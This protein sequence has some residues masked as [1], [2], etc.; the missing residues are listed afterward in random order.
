[1]KNIAHLIL[2]TLL[3]AGLVTKGSAEEKTDS[4]YTGQPL[5]LTIIEKEVLDATYR[6]D[7]EG[8]TLLTPGLLIDAL[9][10]VPNGAALTLRGISTDSAEKSTAP[11]V[12]VM[13]DGIPVGSHLGNNPSLFDIERIEIAKG[14]QSSLTGPGAVAGSINLIRSLPKGVL[15]VT[16]D[17]V[18]TQHGRQETGLVIHL[19]AFKDLAMKFSVHRINGDG[20]YMHNHHWPGRDE[21]REDHLLVSLS[22]LWQINSTTRLH[23]TYD[24]ETDKSETPALLNRSRDFDILCVVYLK[25]PER[26]PN[27]EWLSQYSSFN[28]TAQDYIPQTSMD[29]QYH[30]VAFET[31]IG[32]YRIENRL[33]I[34]ETEE[35][36]FQDLDASDIDLLWRA[37]WQTRDQLSNDLTIYAPKGKRL[38][39]LVGYYYFSS[40][41]NTRSLSQYQYYSPVDQWVTG[42][43]PEGNRQEQ[44]G[45]TLYTHFEWNLDQSSRLEWGLR[46]NRTDVDFTIIAPL[47]CAGCV[48][49]AIVLPPTLTKEEWDK[50]TGDLTY[51]YQIDDTASLA[52]RA[53]K[54]YRYGGYSEAYHSFMQPERVES[55]EAILDKKLFDG[56]GHLKLTLWQSKWDGKV[57]TIPW[58]NSFLLAEGKT[59]TNTSKINLDGLDM[60]F[61]RELD[62]GLKIK[63][64]Y[65]HLSSDY[66]RYTIPDMS[67]SLPFVE[68]DVSGRHPAR[69]P[70]DTFALSLDHSWALGAG[71]LKAHLIW[72]HTEDYTTDPGN[73]RAWVYEFNTTDVSLDYLWRH[74]TFRLFATNLFD[75]RT[76]RNVKSHE[77]TDFQSIQSPLTNATLATSAEY[78]LP[79]YTGLEVRYHLN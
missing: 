15:S 9:S 18:Q 42:I 74:W 11:A 2:P 4:T 67:P 72:R 52:F 1:M 27:P 58:K 14:S 47:R 66:D 25:C 64:T 73:A 17:I 22:G 60:E 49:P 71:R 48:Y 33:G 37:R 16:A 20:E 55:L 61:A 51:A 12:N 32:A 77:V 5:D 21:N 10:A 59:R 75:K 29:G 68:V 70:A 38:N 63:M 34:R 35:A 40:D 45:H 78:N 13:I 56:K 36:V 31:A 30:S 3:L 44:T 57:E 43:A 8:L 53:G 54:E 65:S 24:D 46:Y 39:Y 62:N 69:A 26:E 41:T 23:Y 6:R 50:L 76:S 79:R 28:Q 7:L 19:P